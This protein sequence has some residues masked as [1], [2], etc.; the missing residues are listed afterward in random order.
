MNRRVTIWG[1]QNSSIQMLEKLTQNGLRVT[2]QRRTLVRIFSDYE[3]YLS[4]RDVYNK[5]A[6]HYPGVSFDTVYRNLRFL[7]D[8]GCWSSCILWT[9]DQNSKAAVCRMIIITIIT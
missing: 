9:G 5:M 6:K 4:P 2:E 1:H 3:G 8:M 7:S